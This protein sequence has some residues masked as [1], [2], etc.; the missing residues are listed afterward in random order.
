MI[1]END[2]LLP[3]YHILYTGDKEGV[4]GHNVE[5]YFDDFRTV[6]I[7]DA[8]TVAR[9]TQAWDFYNGH[10][11]KKHALSIK[12][13]YKS[14][15]KV[16]NFQYMKCAP[17]THQNYYRDIIKMQWL[18]NNIIDTGLRE[19][20]TAVTF[21]Y[22]DKDI[23][24]IRYSSVIHPGTFRWYA[25]QICDVNPQCIVFDPFDQFTDYPKATLSECLDLF[26]EESNKYEIAIL[27]NNDNYL[28]PQIM[29]MKDGSTNASMTKAVTEY[30]E[31]V[32]EH[33]H[34]PINIF[35]GYDSRHNDVHE[36]CIK[37]IKLSSTGIE[38]TP[39]I[40]IIPLDIA[41]IPE[42][43]REFANQ[44]VE[45]SY[46]RFLAP[47][48]SDYK[49]WSIFVD[50]D[51]IFES[52]I[53]NLLWFIDD[54]KA[55][56]VVQHDFEKKYDKKF[57]DTKDVWYDKKLWSS[58]MV[59]NNAHPDCQKLT[60]ETINTESGKYL[61]QFEWTENVGKIPDKWAWQEGY[62]PVDEFDD[63]RSMH[64]TRGGYWI[65]NMDIDDIYGMNVHAAYHYINNDFPST[66]KSYIDPRKYFYMDFIARK[67][68][69][70]YCQ[71]KDL[72]E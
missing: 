3:I 30:E 49:G 58:L 40:N 13:F 54:T 16:E 32:K 42:Y 9:R 34:S 45:F 59:F 7:V 39:N 65:N 63:A 48:L 52:D 35:V 8:N 55:V 6:R 29:N 50:N 12:T 70:K 64:W 47:Y 21:P 5:K 20:V 1:L 19:P 22:K 68:N 18:C 41:D 2:P 31:R 27:P 71:P 10:M 57:G 33:W 44:S 61:H 43:D 37:S 28:T 25:F 53:L 36:T 4:K 62:S 26:T 46:S 24:K 38:N 60:P 17:D 14:K 56:S 23:G 72:G 67:D 51:Y 69:S 11:L 15:E 66:Y